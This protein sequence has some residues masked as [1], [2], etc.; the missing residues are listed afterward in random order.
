MLVLSRSDVLSLLSLPDYIEAVEAA[1]RS[2][3]ARRTLG[4]GVLGVPTPGGG[5]HVKVAELVGDRSV[6]AAKINANYPDNPRRFELPT[7]QG[8]VMLADGVK[9]VPLAFIESGSLT[10]LRTG[11]ATAIAAKFLARKDAHAVTLVGCGVQGETQIAALAAV[12]PIDRVWLVDSVPA[13][14]EALAE[15]AATSHPAC[16]SP[17]SARTA[18]ASRSWILRWWQARRSLS[19]CSISAPRSVSSSIRSRPA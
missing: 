19:T 6:F 18:R 7:I 3:A 9:D 4:P 13:R 16:S 5:F 10:A 12:L 15:R 14:A 11:A 17:R 8:V 1:F 2:H